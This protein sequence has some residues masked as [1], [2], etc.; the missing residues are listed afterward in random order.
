MYKLKNRL[1]EVM[2]I[3]TLAITTYSGMRE[4]NRETGISMY[5]LHKIADAHTGEDYYITTE[6]GQAYKI[7]CKLDDSDPVIIAYPVDDTMFAPI[8][9][10]SVT[11]LM[12]QFG[13]GKTTIYRRWAE[14][15]PV[16][17]ENPTQLI[18]DYYQNNI[19]VICKNGNAYGEKFIL[20][21]YK[22][23]NKGDKEAFESNKGFGRNG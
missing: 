15:Y 18:V 5:S 6:K 20:R 19:P 17:Q 1:F 2:D 4:C 13:I 22:A 11:K 7:T 9:F 8:K 3:S 23:Y 10:K 12:Q 21:F 16:Y 14:A